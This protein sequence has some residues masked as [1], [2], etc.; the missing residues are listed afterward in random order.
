MKFYTA[1]TIML[2]PLYIAC[3]KSI[4]MKQS[5]QTSVEVPMIIEALL[6]M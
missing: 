4:I 6:R 1:L 3:V 5:N 2:I